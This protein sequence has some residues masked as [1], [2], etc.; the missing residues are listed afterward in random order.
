MINISEIVAKTEAMF[1]L[2]N[3]HFYNDDMTRLYNLIH[4]I[5]VVSNNGSASILP[6]KRS[7]K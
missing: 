1:D 3:D 5:K 4:G 7:C 2:F 6:C